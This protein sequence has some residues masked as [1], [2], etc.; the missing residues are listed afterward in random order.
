MKAL[1][2]YGSTMGDTEGVANKIAG[3]LSCDA[4]RVSEG[5]SM[6]NDYELILFGSS[7]WGLGEL[8]DEWVD[9][10]DELKGANLSG[11]KI[12]VFGTG[13]QFAY[14]DTFCDAIGIIAKAA[15]E[16][17]GVIVGKTSKEGYTFDASVALEGDE[18]L[19][20]AIDVNNQ[21][22]LTDSRIESWLDKIKNEI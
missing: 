14:T 6:L 20:L 17:G 1:V 9:G 7:T 13:D 10:I 4:V 8:Q 16:A 2:V 11:K 21:D 15:E 3:D 5:L 18:L 22:D 19:G 12:G